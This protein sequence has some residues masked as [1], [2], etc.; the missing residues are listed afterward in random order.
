M[1]NGSCIRKEGRGDETKEKK[2]KGKT[3]RGEKGSPRP[4][5]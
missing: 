2:K 3:I 1:S 5:Q 4:L